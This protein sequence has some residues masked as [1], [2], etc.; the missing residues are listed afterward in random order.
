MLLQPPLVSAVVVVHRLVVDGGR[1][2]TRDVSRLGRHIQRF[3]R[4][5]NRRLRFALVLLRHGLSQQRRC[6]RHPDAGCGFP[7]RD[8]LR[9]TT[10]ITQFD[11]VIEP[12]ADDGIVHGQN[13]F[14]IMAG[15]NQHATSL[16]DTKVGFWASST[17]STV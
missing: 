17:A 16:Y 5:S 12:A 1:D 3:D 14:Y 15:K 11:G 9:M 13:R 7:Q 10:G 6:G 8:H 2:G 4:V